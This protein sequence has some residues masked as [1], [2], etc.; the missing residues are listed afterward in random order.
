MALLGL[1]YHNK[2][3][4]VKFLMA[5]NFYFWLT[6]LKIILVPFVSTTLILQLDEPIKDSIQVDVA[7]FG[8]IEFINILVEY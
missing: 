8:P 6:L 5:I 2:I 7:I 4:D 3:N 1:I